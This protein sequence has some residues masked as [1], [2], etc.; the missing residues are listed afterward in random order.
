MNE[1][2]K[3]GRRSREF[4]SAT[5]LAQ[6]GVCEQRIRL[7]SKL[8]RRQ[9]VGQQRAADRGTARHLDFHRDA[10]ARQPGVSTSEPVDKRCFIAC[11]VFGEAPET[12][13]LRRFRDKVLM[14][15]RSGRAFVAFYYKWSPALASFLQT[16]SGSKRVVAA[17]LR[18][19]A[20]W[21]DKVVGPSNLPDL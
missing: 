19:I 17:L 20:R 16:R 12:E 14:K 13:A 21:A 10:V 2:R 3:G 1:A 8:G 11:A 18:P 6:M 7:T 4:T 15:S 5:D 9:S